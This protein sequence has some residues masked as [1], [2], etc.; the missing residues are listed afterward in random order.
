MKAQTNHSFSACCW[1]GYYMISL[2]HMREILSICCEAES[3]PAQ[4]VSLL[5]CR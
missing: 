1:M 5:V 4:E 2:C 3:A